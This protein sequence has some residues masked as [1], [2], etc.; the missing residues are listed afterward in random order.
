MENIE[1]I[2][3]D[4]EPYYY[5]LIGVAN[6][7]LELL[8][9][10][11]KPM[12]REFEYDVPI[13]NQQGEVSGRLRVRLQLVVERKENDEE[14]RTLLRLCIDR[15]FDLPVNLNN[16]VF[17]QYR[18]GVN[19]N[20]PIVVASKDSSGSEVF[21]DYE[22]ELA[23]NAS[24]HDEHEDLIEY[25][26]DGGALSI[27]VLAYRTDIAKPMVAGSAASNQLRSLKIYQEKMIELNQAAK[28]QA[29]VDAWS[30][31]SRSFELNVRIL[32]LNADGNWNPVEV[33]TSAKIKTG[34][35]YQ[36]R[37]GQSRQISK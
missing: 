18:W 4:N 21:F 15:A 12:S 23:M 14:D 29:L 30:K 20:K 10:K 19:N 2:F 16:L 37:Q 32:E 11:D 27:E 25:F 1:S 22:T 28:M 9:V 7:F 13:V 3:A 33:R 34:G 8:V 24:G 6:I 5:K 36:L 31:L 17:C 26:S 35:V